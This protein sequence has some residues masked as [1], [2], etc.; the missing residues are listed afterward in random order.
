M[1]M[2]PEGGPH[3]VMAAGPDPR[4]ALS[5]KSKPRTGFLRLEPT[6]SLLSLLRGKQF[7]EFPT[8]EVW[9][10]FR[11]LVVDPEGSIAQEAEEDQRPV[12]RR[13]LN[14]KASKKAIHSLLGGYGSDSEE[15]ETE[16][17]P[18]GLS[19]LGGYAGSEDE[20]TI[21]SQ[22]NPDQQSSLAEFS[23][24]ES[25]GEVDPATLLELLRKA[26]HNDAWADSGSLQEEELDWGASD[27][28]S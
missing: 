18:N 13:K 5:Q 20:G 19:A 24:D 16:N 22:H 27:E 12:K 3:C 21:S 10:E 23:D 9:E 1:V 28:E 11:G 15:E 17:A 25:E 14:T 6:K 7:T 2:D 4:L 26:G 8:I